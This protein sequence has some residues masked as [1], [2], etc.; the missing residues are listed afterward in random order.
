MSNIKPPEVNIKEPMQLK[1]P[2]CG[3]LLEFRLN[4]SFLL[5]SLIFYCQ[6]CNKKITV[7]KLNDK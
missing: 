2:F 7:V 4:D 6:N 5:A 3:E 1:C